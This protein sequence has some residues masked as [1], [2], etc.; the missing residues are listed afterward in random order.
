MCKRLA[1]TQGL[2]VGISA[3]AAVAACLDV[4]EEEARA[5]REAIIVTILCDSA[6]KYLSERFWS[7]PTPEA[8]A[9][10]ALDTRT[11]RRP[12]RLAS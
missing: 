2:L 8:A 1:Q 3:G 4:A 7:E 9:H 5:G 11:L 10:D 12:K 6:D